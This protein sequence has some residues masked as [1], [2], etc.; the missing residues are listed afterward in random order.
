MPRERIYIV[1]FMGSGKTTI[2]RK[3]AA[4]L[5]W[6]FI[7]LDE[8]I[9]KK[10][11]MK[12]PEIFSRL[13]EDA[14]RLTESEVLRQS[15][16]MKNI[17]IST[18]GGAP[19]HDSNMD[20]MLESGLTVYLKLTP[21]QLRSRLQSSGTVRPLIK[22]LENGELLQFIRHRLTQRE[23][24]YKRAEIIVEGAEVDLV[25]LKKLIWERI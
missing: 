19:C 13:G 3:L 24:Y 5:G 10:T 18:G 25:S 17:V 21:G 20:Y 9:E 11:S 1:G 2:G 22:G 14:F 12:I 15:E 16:Q 8:R 4:V 23:E 7:D 6:N